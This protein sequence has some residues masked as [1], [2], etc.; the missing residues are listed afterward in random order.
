MKPDNYR[1]LLTTANAKTSK[2]EKLGILTGIL[3]LA[4]ANEARAEINICAGATE[5]CRKGCL[6]T[7]GRA[8]FTPNIITARIAKT[9]FLFD[10]RDAFLESLRYDIRAL[11]RK[12]KR[13][14]KR[15]AVR[16]N[17]TSDLPWIAL[18]M[19]AEFPDVQF[20]D[21]TKLL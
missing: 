19:A 18:Q 13:E 3:Y 21:Y 20:Y 11:V 10:N 16:I 17:G 12:A 9:H 2:G 1:R 5:G 4:P 6:F 14:N 7:A 8:S 15:A